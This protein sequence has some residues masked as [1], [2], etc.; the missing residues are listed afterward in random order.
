MN[1]VNKNTSP[2][3]TVIVP[4][5]NA[6]K[7]LRQCV[8]SILVQDFKDFELLLVDDGSK[9][10]SPAICD[11][12]AEK[13]ARVRVFHKE[14]GGVSSAR[15][16]G[17]DNAKGEWIT[18]ID[19]D[20]FITEGYFEGVVGREENVLIKGYKS[21]TTNGFEGGKSADKLNHIPEFTSFLNRYITDS[22]IRCPWAK[23]YKKSIIGNLRFITDM[24]IGEDAYFVF[25]YLAK[26]NNFI[27]LPDGEYT[28]RLADKPD[29]VK[30]ANSVDYAAQ[31]LS[32]LKEA[33]N[34]LVNAHGIDKNHFLSYIG[35]FKRI[36]KSDWQNDKSKW[37]GNKEIRASYKY[38]WSA[39]TTKQ[40]LSFVLKAISK[41]VT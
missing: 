16:V 12:Y 14:N 33:F 40:K 4:V 5:Y 38:V 31:T 1:E 41:L 20:D 39:L 7:T 11:E 18:F 19:S 34:E 24:K 3:I 6:E 17:L 26:C 15:N 29:E 22:L 35:Y 32:H 36:S 10:G 9:D 8:D 30:Y 23:F 21:F 13:D 27:V 28:V 2:A 37:Y 25:K